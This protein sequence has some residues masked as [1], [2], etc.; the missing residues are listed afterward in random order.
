MLHVEW[1]EPALS[2]LIEAQEYYEEVNSQAAKLLAQ[3]VWD[4]SNKLA[5]QPS[6]G[7][8]VT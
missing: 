1:T 7:R 4:V 6:I 3:R 5:E 8:V 2:D